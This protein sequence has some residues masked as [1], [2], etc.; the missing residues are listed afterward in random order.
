[1]DEGNGVLGR[2][3]IKDIVQRNIFEA[4]ILAD[5]VVV[6]DVNSSGNAKVG[7][8]DL[9]SK[10]VVG[11]PGAS[12]GED[13]KGGEVWSRK[14]VFLKVDG[15]RELGDHGWGSFDKLTKLNLS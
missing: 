14:L 2:R 1:M 13:F 15:P 11:I 7:M 3:G 9:Q 4:V 5:G 12:E 6:W 8:L 10:D